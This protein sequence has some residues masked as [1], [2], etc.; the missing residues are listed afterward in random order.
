MKHYAYPGVDVR[1]R[2]GGIDLVEYDI[3]DLDEDEVSSVTK[4][5]EAAA[6]ANFTVN[7]SAT[8]NSAKYRDDVVVM[9]VR[10]DGRS[11][12]SR[13]YTIDTAAA[14]IVGK[15][16]HNLDGI[17]TNTATGMMLE[18]FTFAELQTSRSASECWMA[19]AD[20]A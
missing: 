16:V 17:E 11:I 1:L 20:M 12:C 19:L 6:G 5:V 10:L 13:I 4:Y 15:Y 9:D 7:F 14:R 18:K 3:D 2:V 8:P